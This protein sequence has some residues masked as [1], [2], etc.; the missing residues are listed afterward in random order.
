[1]TRAEDDLR[2]WHA[3]KKSG[4]PDDFR[5]LL[6]AYDGVIHKFVGRYA[7]AGV[8]H[9]ALETEA[10]LNAKKAFETFKPE[11]G[12]QLNTHVENMLQKTQR[13]V[14]EHKGLTRIPEHR[15]LKVQTYMRVRDHLKD[16]LNRPPT[17]AE[18]Q[19]EL[20]ASKPIGKE[21]DALSWSSSEVSRMEKE[22]HRTL[23][24]S[25]DSLQELESQVP[26]QEGKILDWLYDELK[27]EEQSVYEHLV[28][29]GGKP[30]LEGKDIA[31]TLNMSPSKVSR[32]RQRIADKFQAF[33]DRPTMV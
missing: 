2:L 5:T 20:M 27:P 28:G 16:R 17:L 25:E 19:G 18:M 32:I 14:H 11:L 10:K 26:S 6:R 9:A 3:W 12:N 31:K 24:T 8:P 30:R 7:H 15:A 23:L 13:L 1:M 4:H 22:L 29:R 33:A 21:H